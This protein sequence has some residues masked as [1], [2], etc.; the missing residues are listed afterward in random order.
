VTLGL[1]DTSTLASRTLMG[2]LQTEPDAGAWF[3]RCR[4]RR[5]DAAVAQLWGWRTLTDGGDEMGSAA[6]FA[7]LADCVR[8]ARRHGFDGDV[9]AAHGMFTASGYEIRVKLGG[10]APCR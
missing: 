5:T 8:D 3:F 10:V 2:A 7:T 6:V 1:S 9:D 4:S